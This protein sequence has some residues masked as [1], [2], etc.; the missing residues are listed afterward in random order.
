MEVLVIRC[1]KKKSA[2]A[3]DIVG[4]GQVIAARDRDMELPAGEGW[5]YVEARLHDQDPMTMPPAFSF[6]FLAYS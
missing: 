5:P 3:L 6:Q 4:H 2:L 1:Q